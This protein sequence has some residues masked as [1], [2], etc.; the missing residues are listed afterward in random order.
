MVLSAACLSNLMS[1]LNFFL[2]LCHDSGFLLIQIVVKYN[3]NKVGNASFVGGGK[4]LFRYKCLQKGAKLPEAITA[5]LEGESFEDVITA[6]PLGGD[7]D[8]LTAIVGSSIVE[9]FYGVPGE[10]R[11]ECHKR[12]PDPLHKVL[13][14]FEKYIG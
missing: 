2:R 5:F 6:V 1:I 4:S 7:C 14:E 13:L 8:T 11:T 9:R 3:Y 12:L 10:L